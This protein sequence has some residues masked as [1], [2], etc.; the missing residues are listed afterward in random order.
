MCVCDDVHFHT[1]SCI[2]LIQYPVENPE[3]FLQFGMTPSMSVSV[4]VSVCA[5]VSVCVR[6]TL[7]VCTICFVDS[8]CCGNMRVMS[9]IMTSL[10]LKSTCTFEEEQG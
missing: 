7:V 1:Y 2:L 8:L 9:A 4:S 6:T 10:F 3:K 5:C